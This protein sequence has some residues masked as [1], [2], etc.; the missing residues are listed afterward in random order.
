MADEA[1]HSPGRTAFEA[2]AERAG[3]RSLVT[4]QD[5]PP[6]DNTRQEVR[7]AWEAAAEAVLNRDEHS[8]LR[9]DEDQREPDV[10]DEGDEK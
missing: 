10:P 1:Q 7:D 6:W 3:G 2:Y 9:F 4:G 5:I 8:W